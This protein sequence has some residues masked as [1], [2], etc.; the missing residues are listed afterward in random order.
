MEL[1]LEH[2]ML[3]IICSNTRSL[4][5]IHLQ[6]LRR[7]L[8]AECQQPMIQYTTISNIDNCHIAV[9]SKPEHSAKRFICF[10]VLSFFWIFLDTSIWPQRPLLLFCSLWKNWASLRRYGF[11]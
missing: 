11:L 5:A 7:T 1:I 10:S 3:L 8:R 6:Q 4:A 9:V 2:D